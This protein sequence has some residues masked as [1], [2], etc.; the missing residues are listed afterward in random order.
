MKTETLIK[1]TLINSI[2]SGSFAWK[3]YLSGG[4]WRGIELRTLP[5]MINNR[6][7]GYS[8]LIYFETRHVLTIT[9]DWERK[10]TYYAYT[11]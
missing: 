6:Q 2:N 5:T 9:H 11:K 1:E 8:V 10:Y 4:Y 3:R 7:T